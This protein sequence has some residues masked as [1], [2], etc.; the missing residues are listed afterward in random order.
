MWRLL[1]ARGPLPQLLKVGPRAAARIH[2]RDGKARWE[3]AHAASA[4]MCAEPQHALSTTGKEAPG[5]F[6]FHLQR[7]NVLVS[8][9]H[10]P[11]QQHR[12]RS[13]D[14]SVRAAD[15]RKLS[16]GWVGTL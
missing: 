3:R 9:S 1:T 12:R 16:A 10:R 15:A 8:V 5:F 7:T 14:C 6:I 4:G 2:A 13:C 11:W